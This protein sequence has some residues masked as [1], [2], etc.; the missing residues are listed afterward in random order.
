MKRLLNCVCVSPKDSGTLD[1]PAR[2]SPDGYQNKRDAGRG[3]CMGNNILDAQWLLAY[4]AVSACPDADPE[5]N[6]RYCLLSKNRNTL[7]P[8]SS[9]GSKALLGRYLL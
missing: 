8:V 2:G 7:H 3:F 6:R 9:L 5:R 4:S 1:I